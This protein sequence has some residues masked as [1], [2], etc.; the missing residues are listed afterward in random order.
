MLWIFAKNNGKSNFKCRNEEESNAK[1]ES[2]TD[3]IKHQCVCI[4]CY[5][6]VDVQC[7]TIVKDT[8]VFVLAVTHY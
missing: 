5:K 7:H 2:I 8:T 1:V 6:Q 4:S 3:H